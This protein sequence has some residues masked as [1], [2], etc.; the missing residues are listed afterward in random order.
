MGL[1]DERHDAAGRR[2]EE[3]VGEA[4]A[5]GEHEQQ[6]KREPAAGVDDGQCAD[7]H[8]ARDVG[9][10]H[11]HPARVAVGQRASHE[12]CRQEGK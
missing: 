8:K 7:D 2:V 6:G 4:E 9:R 5:D 1:H 3:P 12:Q 11:Q 10:D